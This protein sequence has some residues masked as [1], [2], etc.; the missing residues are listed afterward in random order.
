MSRPIFGGVNNDMKI[1]QEEIF[2]PV[3]ATLTFDDIEQVAELA[4][5]NVYGLAA[6]V[7]TN[8]IKKAHQLSRRL[9]A[10]TV[11]INTYGVMD[12]AMPFRRLQ[13][14]RLWPRAGH[15]RD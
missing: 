3:L 5:K 13:A 6:A 7:W 15:A 8:D 10:G 9:K 2:G 12:A 1:A 14:V 4:N 11:W